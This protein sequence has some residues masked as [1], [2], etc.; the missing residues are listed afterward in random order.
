MFSLYF[1]LNTFEKKVIFTFHLKKRE[2][3][4]FIL[5][6]FKMLL[7]W[8]KVFF[9]RCFEKIVFYN[10]Y[11]KMLLKILIC[12]SIYFCI[13]NIYIYISRH[14]LINMYPFSICV[15]THKLNLIYTWIPI[16][17]VNSK[18]NQMILCDLSIY[19]DIIIFL[20][21]L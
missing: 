1:L 12:I 17:Y 19:K 18:Q 10:F 4:Y 16:Q 13:L 14:I 11:F 20:F 21:F 8:E 15:F 7:F 6:Y 9:S 5:F 3:Q 2:K